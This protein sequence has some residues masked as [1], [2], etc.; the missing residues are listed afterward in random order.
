M[1][2]DAVRAAILL[3]LVVQNSAQ[4]IFMRYS[5][6]PKDQ[7]EGAEKEAE[8]ASSTAVVMAELCKF[9]CSII[10]LYRENGSVRQVA[11]TLKEDLWDK[12]VDLLKMAVPACLYVLQNNLNYVAISN[13][14]GPTFQLL[15]QLKILTTAL[16]SVLMLKRV[17]VAKQWGALAMLALGVGLVQ[18]SSSTSGK[19]DD[20]SGDEGDVGDGQDPLLGLAAVLM[21]CCTSGF[22]G[23]YFEKVLK[24]TSVSLWVRN[25]QLSGFGVLLGVGCVWF[26]DGEAVS[27]HGFFYG[28]NYAVWMSVL[29][30]SMGG[31]VVAMVV[32]YADNVVK[33]FATSVSIVLT[34]LI[35]VVLFG[36]HITLMFVVGAYFVL[37]S[38]IL[39]SQK[40][41]S[42]PAAAPAAATSGAVATT[43]T[44]N[45]ITS[46][47]AIGDMELPEKES[48]LG[49][50]GYQSDSPR[51]RSGKATAASE[52]GALA[53]K[54]GKF[55]MDPV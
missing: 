25:M 51:S 54:G 44:A 40:P 9:F 45:G 24:G 39:Y 34:A 26:K 10:L 49:A 42:A 37:H 8:P 23:V 7:V 13:L 5:F 50:Q 38:T 55:D 21:A 4:A 18:V 27:E 12:P 53:R 6:K 31:L 20:D 15:Y 1:S 17:L 48:L 43:G 14:D 3:T 2:P 22:A 32:K 41:P 19:D 11:Q 36:F 33:G 30:N 28:Y 29:L 52:G 35:S 47:G 16:F 46:S